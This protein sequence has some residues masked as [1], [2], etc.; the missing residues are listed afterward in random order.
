MPKEVIKFGERID[1]DPVQDPNVCAWSGQEISGTQDTIR[2]SLT[3]DRFVRY[4]SRYAHHVTKEVIEGWR[5]EVSPKPKKKEKAE[6][7]KE[8]NNAS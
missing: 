8:V 4:K 3:P 6:Y 7:T 5:G 1:G 2:Q